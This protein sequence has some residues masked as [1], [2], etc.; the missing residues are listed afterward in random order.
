MK[1]LRRPSAEG[2]NRRQAAKWPSVWDPIGIRTYLSRVGRETLTSGW[3]AGSQLLPASAWTF[4]SHTWSRQWTTSGVRQCGFPFL[5]LRL[6]PLPLSPPSLFVLSGT[7]ILAQLF[8]PCSDAQSLS[9]YGALDGGSPMSYV[10]F[11]KWQC[12]LS[13][14]VY[15]PCRF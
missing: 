8:L 7:P 5:P 15:F 1:R 2:Q 10:E 13:L 6:L 12:P 9:S 3:V 4:D 14:F 11:K